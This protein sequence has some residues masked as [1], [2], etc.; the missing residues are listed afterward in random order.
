MKIILVLFSVCISFNLSAQSNSHFDKM[1]DNSDTLTIKIN[2]HGKIQNAEEVKILHKLLYNKD[3]IS[4]VAKM[5][6]V[7]PD[8]NYDY[9]LKIIKPD[10]IQD[11]IMVKKF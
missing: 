10:V 7:T 9:K 4:S 5:P 3:S 11:S 1:K 6:T 2:K 8:K